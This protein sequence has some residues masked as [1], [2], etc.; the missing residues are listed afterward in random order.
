MGRRSGSGPCLAE[1][2]PSLTGACPFRTRL[3]GQHP[4]LPMRFSQADD[5]LFRDRCLSRN[6]SV[7]VGLVSTRLATDSSPVAVAI[8]AE[9]RS[10]ALRLSSWSPLPQPPWCTYSRGRPT[11]TCRSTFG[12][13]CIS[14]SLSDTGRRPYAYSLLRRRDRWPLWGPTV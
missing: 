9:P 12:T 14:A 5:G 11:C 1:F 10:L 3:V 7:A 4:F 6:C 2:G 8:S 13:R